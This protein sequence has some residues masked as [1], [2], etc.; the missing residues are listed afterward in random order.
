M[1][2][3]ALVL[4]L[5]V[6]AG[7]TPSPPAPTAQTT[8]VQISSVPSG[9]K[10]VFDGKELDGVTPLELR[11][12]KAFEAHEVEVLMPGQE[13]WKKRFAPA[14]GVKTQLKAEFA[15]AAPP[16]GEAPPEPVPAPAPAGEVADA[17][18]A[19]PAP[20]PTLD[21][22]PA[23]AGGTPGA[24]DGGTP[25]AGADALD[26]GDAGQDPLHATWPVKEV[27]VDGKVSALWVPEAGGVLVNLNPKKSYRMWTEGVA[28]TRKGSSSASLRYF[29][30]GPQ[31]WQDE[32]LGTLG[33]T[34]K[35]IKGARKLW[36][37][38]FDDDV[39]DNSGQLRVYMQE[40]KLV[41]PTKIAW[42]PKRKEDVII[43]DPTKL[44]TLDGL[45]PGRTYTFSARTLELYMR[46]RPWG[47]LET[48]ICRLDGEGPARFEVFPMKSI[49]KTVSEAK[50]MTCFFLDASVEPNEGC[51]MIDFFNA[52]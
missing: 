38:E 50:S 43:P 29:V 6:A 5:V 31:V 33:V 18:V 41:A 48:F 39:S 40:S 15:V 23:P 22:G 19:P 1:T 3:R 45:N 13:S 8:T 32:A 11:S 30:E 24:T 44:F 20:A 49:S 52:P 34:P 46:E 14:A 28:S 25:P 42:D 35:V 16:P 37:F 27:K 17:G 9:L 10:V 2:L 47:R 51:M 7:C 4:A 26:G 12:V 36:L 21:A